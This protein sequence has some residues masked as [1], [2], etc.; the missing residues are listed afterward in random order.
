MGRASTHLFL[1]W[2]WSSCKSI[3]RKNRD[4]WNNLEYRDRLTLILAAELI[5]AVMAQQNMNALSGGSEGAGGSSSSFVFSSTQL[6]G[7]GGGARGDVDSDG[8]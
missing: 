5:Y 2:P 8:K 7:G 1:L 4:T 3:H 6:G